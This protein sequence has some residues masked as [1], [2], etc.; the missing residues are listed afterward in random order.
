MLHA[1][2]GLSLRS[3]LIHPASWH[4]GVTRYADFHSRCIGEVDHVVY[5]TV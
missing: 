2:N 1:G 5:E 4:L 3:A